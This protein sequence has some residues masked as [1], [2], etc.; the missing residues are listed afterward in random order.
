MHAIIN[1][2][3]FKSWGIFLMFKQLT[4]SL[5]PFLIKLYI[6]KIALWQNMLIAD[7]WV[8]SRD[9][10]YVREHC[11][12]VTRLCAVFDRGIME[13]EKPSAHY[14]W[15]GTNS[16]LFNAFKNMD[17]ICKSSLTPFP[18]QPVTIGQRFVLW[19]NLTLT[20]TKDSLPNEKFPSEPWY[21]LD[22]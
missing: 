20:T 13:M 7:V 19:K 2:S 8:T 18:L 6:P 22:Q 11:L 21:N 12:A 16:R 1:L 4:V 9:W 3:Q 15:N 14:S 10:P 5:L 17:S